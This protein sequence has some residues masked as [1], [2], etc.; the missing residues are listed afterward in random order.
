MMTRIQ[1]T[2]GISQTIIDNRTLS[3]RNHM[4]LINRAIRKERVSR[5]F[6]IFFVRIITMKAIMEGLN[7]SIKVTKLFKSPKIKM[8]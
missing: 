5:V 8:S 6:K 7:T 2:H 4:P 1:S 3:P